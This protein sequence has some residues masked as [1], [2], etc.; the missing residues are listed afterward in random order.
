MRYRAKECPV[1]CRRSL[2]LLIPPFASDTGPN[3]T[4]KTINRIVADGVKRLPN[5]T[6]RRQPSVLILKV[7]IVYKNHIQGREGV[8]QGWQLRLICA[9]VY[10]PEDAI[11]LQPHRYNLFL[12]LTHNFFF[13]SELYSHELKQIIPA[14]TQRSLLWPRQPFPHKKTTAN[15]M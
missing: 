6:S 9:F 7:L 14:Q 10:F 13:L 5:K 11:G 12:F 2:L 3:S 8:G 15:A 1:S 4:G